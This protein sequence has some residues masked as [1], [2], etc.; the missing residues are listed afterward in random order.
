[1]LSLA[2]VKTL[3]NMEGKENRL[4]A[5]LLRQVAADRSS[6]FV[7]VKLGKGLFT[8]EADLRA[9]LPELFARDVIDADS[10]AGRVEALAAEVRRLKTK[11]ERL[12]NTTYRRNLETAA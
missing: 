9:L 3:M 7:F 6:G 2:Q 12:E 8:T 1:M 5:R 11:V 10:Y 4:V